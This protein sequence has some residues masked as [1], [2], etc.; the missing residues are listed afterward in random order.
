LII[1]PVVSSP[2]Q[3]RRKEDK[4]RQLE[5][6]IKKRQEYKEKTKGALVFDHFPSE[7]KSKG[8]GRGRGGDYVSDS[9]SDVSRRGGDE[10]GRPP[11]ERKKK[12]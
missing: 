12:R 11:R 3:K 5:E 6:E 9:D 8:R 4:V 7:K 1:T 10:E 2:F